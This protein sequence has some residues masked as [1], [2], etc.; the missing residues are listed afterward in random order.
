MKNG[1]AIN[2]RP[3]RKGRC[4]AGIHFQSSLDLE[5]TGG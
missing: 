1:T 2:I 4:V 5:D 3:K